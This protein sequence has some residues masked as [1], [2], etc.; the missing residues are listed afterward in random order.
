M[1]DRFT[2]QIHIFKEKKLRLNLIVFLHVEI[3][4]NKRIFF[5]FKKLST[6]SSVLMYLFYK[7]KCI[8]NSI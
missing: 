1:F 3:V 5:K 8:S 6:E 2:S 4:R 7:L